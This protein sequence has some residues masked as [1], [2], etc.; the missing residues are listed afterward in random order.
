MTSSTPKVCVHLR[1]RQVLFVAPDN[2][3]ALSWGVYGVPDMYREA[4]G[5]L[6]VHDDGR[7]DSHDHD[8]EGRV[9]SVT[10][11]SA[12]NGRTWAPYVRPGEGAFGRHTEGYG[13]PNKVFHLPDGSRVQFLPTQPPVDLDALGIRPL[14]LAMSANE[15]GLNGLYRQADLPPATRAFKVLY[16]PAGAVT[17]EAAEASFD[18]PEWVFDATIKAKTGTGMWPDVTPT[19]APLMSGNGGL[20]CG[21]SGQ[22]AMVVAPDGAWLTAIIQRIRCERNSHSCH[23]LLCVASTDCG[24]TWRARGTIIPR[25]NTRFGASNEFSMIWVGGEILCVSRLDHATVYDPHHQAVLARSSDNGLTWSTPEI[26]ASTS[27][28]PHLVR[29]DNGIVALVYGRPGV[30]I[31]F[32]TDAGR[33]WSEPTSLIGPTLE[34]ELAAGRDV[35]TAMYSNMSSY[36]NTRTAVT[37]PDR[38]LVLYSD[39]KYGTGGQGKAIVVQEVVVDTEYEVNRGR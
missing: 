29:L 8:A 9:P 27:V 18:V 34:Q 2:E 21:P 20:Y 37:G 35:A 14:W 3:D 16:W 30:H 33:S 26:V 22:E 6:V 4:D 19:F 1:E 7:E 10:L 32:S 17:P 24:R 28:T 25:G 39:F 36:S 11:R 31:R 5:S 13:A 23:E 12:D 15:Y 38:F